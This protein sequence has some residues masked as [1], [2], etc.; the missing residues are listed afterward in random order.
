M[1]GL[2]VTTKHIG[3][4]GT[5]SAS[6]YEPYN[7]GTG[8]L[9]LHRP[10]QRRPRRLNIVTSANDYAGAELRPRQAAAARRPL[11]SGAAEFIDIV[12]KLWDRWEDDALHPR[13]GAG[14]VLRPGQAAV[15]DHE[16]PYF[17]IH[18]ALNIERS[19]QGRPVIIQAGASEAGMEF[20]APAARR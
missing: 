3:L 4:G 2:A 20:A 5:V 9:R 10:Y 19:P 8:H 13:P 16:G 17:K 1:A 6:F 12:L 15:L 7:L 14:P 18:G 11:P